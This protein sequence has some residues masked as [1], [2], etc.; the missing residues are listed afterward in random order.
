MRAAHQ[1]QCQL[2]SMLTQI[3]E[4]AIKEGNENAKM[5]KGYASLK[6]DGAALPYVTSWS[7]S[8]L[9]S[10]ILWQEDKKA[11]RRHLVQIKLEAHFSDF[12]AVS[13]PGKG[14]GHSTLQH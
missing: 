14:S 6:A 11:P 4:R 1:K 10:Q 9:N 7:M 5:I 2:T 3:S 12:E 8:A 13:V